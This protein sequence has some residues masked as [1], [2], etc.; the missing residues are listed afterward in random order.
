MTPTPTLAE[1][2]AEVLRLSHALQRLTED[3]RQAIKRDGK[4]IAQ[5]AQDRLDNR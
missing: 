1:P 4:I 2:Q 5:L 3:H